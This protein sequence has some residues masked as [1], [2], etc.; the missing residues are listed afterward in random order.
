MGFLDVGFTPR[1]NIKISIAA[2]ALVDV[3]A[4]SDG[5]ARMA[6]AVCGKVE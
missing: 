3:P 5:E 6:A 2:N 1:C 4:P